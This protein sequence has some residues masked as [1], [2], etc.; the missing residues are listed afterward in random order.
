MKIQMAFAALL[1]MALSFAA[2]VQARAET[3]TICVYDPAGRSGDYF[4][5]MSKFAT[6]ASTWG[7]EVE[8]RPYTDEETAAKDYEAAQCDGV[9]ATGVRLQRF[10]RFSS[11]I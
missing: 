6:Q 8:I 9:S 7:V 3:R 10:N 1:S 5:L 11:T 2:P 4:S